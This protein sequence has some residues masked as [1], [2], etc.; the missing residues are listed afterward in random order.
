MKGDKRTGDFDQASHWQARG[1]DYLAEIS[2]SDGIAGYF[3]RQEEEFGEFLSSLDLS[4]VESVLEVG[5]G[6]G[7]M[8]PVIAGA[9]PRL[10]R[11]VCLDISR[12]QIRAA[13]QALDTGLQGRVSF[14]VS[15]FHQ[16]AL[17]ETFDLVI[18]IEVLLH[19]PPEQISSVLQS[20]QALSKSWL[21]HVDPF[22][23][24]RWP[25]RH[26]LKGFLRDMQR[27]LLGRRQTTDWRHA[28]PD[29]Y[30][31]SR[32][33]EIAMRP[34]LG[35]WHHVFALKMEHHNEGG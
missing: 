6:Y 19:F 1:D 34:I 26:R 10:H 21:I 32:P 15:D 4:S 17:A 27:S 3:R 33:L 14:V 35:G 30:D 16:P 20:A 29:L 31:R 28:Y 9:L 18:F 23:E 12:G 13:K 2:D 8:T 5:C 24:Y 11:H 7:R 25:L 22:E